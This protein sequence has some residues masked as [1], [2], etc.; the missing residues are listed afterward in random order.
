MIDNWREYLHN[1]DDE[2][3]LNKIR[4][5]EA[6]GRPIGH[7]GFIKSIENKLKRKFDRKP[8]GRPTKK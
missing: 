4:K 8:M 5:E 2:D 1:K 7:E 3:D 6:E